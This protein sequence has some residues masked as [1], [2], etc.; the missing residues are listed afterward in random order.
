MKNNIL[1]E[2]LKKENETILRKNYYFERDN[3]N[4]LEQMMA[5][6][7]FYFNND[8]ISYIKEKIKNDRVW[9]IIIILFDEV[10]DNTIHIVITTRN[11]DNNSITYKDFKKKN[12][13]VIDNKN[14]LF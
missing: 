7:P 9:S 6:F 10:I 13:G 14:Y 4:L 2:E 5:T 12:I 1:K 8:T 11:Y 3:F